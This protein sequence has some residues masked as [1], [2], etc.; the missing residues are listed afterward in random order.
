MARTRYDGLRDETDGLMDRTARLLRL[1]DYVDR[2]IAVQHTRT[3]TALIR[4]A[5]R[6]KDGNPRRLAAM[7]GS[8]A[9]TSDPAL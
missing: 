6:R 9:D 5:E 4:E 7:L 2:E 8:N 3:R 1:R